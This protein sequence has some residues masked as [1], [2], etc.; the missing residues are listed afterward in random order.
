MSGENTHEAV[1]G[2]QIYRP[3]YIIKKLEKIRDYERFELNFED[4]NII[5]EELEK[6]KNILKK[7]KL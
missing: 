5:T 7:R 1:F 4:L 6:S 3:N 2:S